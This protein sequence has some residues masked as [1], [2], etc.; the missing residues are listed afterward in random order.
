MS[1]ASHVHVNA[2]ARRPFLR[3]RIRWPSG[4]RLFRNTTLL[5]ASAAG[6]PNLLAPTAARQALGSIHIY[7]LGRPRRLPT[8][9][10]DISSHGGGTVKRISCFGGPT[11]RSIRDARPRRSRG[12]DDV[13][14][15]RFCPATNPI[16]R[17]QA[18]C[19][20]ASLLSYYA[21][22]STHTTIWRPCRRSHAAMHVVVNSEQGAGGGVKRVVLTPSTESHVGHWRLLGMPS[23]DS[24]PA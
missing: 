13:R 12:G 21:W 7:C 24:L 4:R 18:E 17:R 16:L 22:S 23:Y 2:T 9:A 3:K 11:W 6:G 5:T 20:L 15:F 14:I 19:A 8:R 1:W 10:V